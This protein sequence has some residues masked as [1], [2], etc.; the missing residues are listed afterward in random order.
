VDAV[1]SYVAD[2]GGADTFSV[3]ALPADPCA[4]HDAVT[5]WCQ[6]RQIHPPSKIA[7][8]NKVIELAGT[9]PLLDASHADLARGLHTRLKAL[10]EA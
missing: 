1:Q 2:R 8:A 6:E 4:R 7:I 10:F 5:A 9:V 3:E